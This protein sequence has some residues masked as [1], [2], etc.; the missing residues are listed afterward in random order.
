VLPRYHLENYFLDEHVWV[1]AFAVIAEQGSWLASPEAIREKL[2]ELARNDVSFAVALKTAA[3]VRLSCGNASIMPKDCRGLSE[4]DLVTKLQEA[5][6][7]EKERFESVLDATKIEATA[8][9]AYAA[10][11]S[12]LDADT[13]EW[14]AIVPAKAILG[15]FATA[16]GVKTGH[17]KRL[18]VNAALASGSDAF[19]DVTEIFRRFAGEPVEDPARA[20]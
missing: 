5:A 2:R 18:Y 14:K 19:D 6:S 17:A 20:A 10:I 12:S 3:D 13:D 15:R 9:A 11:M 8:R 1:R 4:S 7:S 16:A